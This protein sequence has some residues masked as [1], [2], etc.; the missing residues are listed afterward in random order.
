MDA[1]IT[2]IGGGV[3][4]LAI[5]NELSNFYNDIFLLEK[6]LKFGEET[7]SRS[8]EVVHSGIY[9]P[10]N[11][12]K[13]KLCLEGN[14]LMYEFCDLH[15]VKYD[16]I[17]KLIIANSDS[18]MNQL[19]IL[20][21]KAIG[22]GVT[23]FEELNAEQILKLEPN[24]NAKKALHLKDTGVVDSCGF[25]EK[26]LIN[27]QAKGVQIIYGSEVV[28]VSRENNSYKISVLENDGKQ[29]EFSSEIV[30]NA[31]GL[32]SEKISKLSGLI[33]KNYRLYYCKGEYFAVTNGKNNLVKKLIYPVPN[34]NLTGLG[35]HVTIDVDKGMK[36]GPNAIYLHNNLL[37]YKLD[38][39]HKQD[40][41]ESARRFLPFL[42]IN[43]LL[44]GHVGIRP[45]LYKNGS[46]V[47][48]FVI[49]NEVDR[50]YKNF[51]N[52]IGIESPG[53][54][55]S[56]SIAKYVKTLINDK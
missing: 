3:I 36:L 27:S 45:K 23:N 51:I 33:D 14:K 7:S 9:Y 30:I 40:F 6:N 32:N 20:K 49:V 43:D 11:S 53:L 56:L 25:M 10:K 19:E 39:N 13:A 8:S 15:E 4:G 26:L 47:R 38:I 54:T 50:G 22:N 29:F 21:E 55:A 34:K 42:E 44:P 52:L 37:D 12:L 5:A 31:A 16:K 28:D 18:D 17:G 2:I 24:I 48:D 46:P 35:I 1:K 41:L